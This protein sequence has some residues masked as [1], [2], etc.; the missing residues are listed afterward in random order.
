M[1]S[2]LELGL[3]SAEKGGR[4]PR[5]LQGTEQKD[6]LWNLGWLRKQRKLGGQRLLGTG[7]AVDFGEGRGVGQ[8]WGRVE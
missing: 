5:Q 1:S 2:G 3:A 8:R 4:R 6:G 7:K